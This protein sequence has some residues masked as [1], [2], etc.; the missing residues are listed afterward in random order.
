MNILLSNGIKNINIFYEKDEK[1]KPD[2]IA[3]LKSAVS[4]DTN[5]SGRETDIKKPVKHLH[6][7][8]SYF[9][10]NSRVMYQAF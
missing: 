10:L 6:V 2:L 8:I 5:V 1:V 7:I 4:L 9:T 3:G